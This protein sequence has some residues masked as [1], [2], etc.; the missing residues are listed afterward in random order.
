V[1][2][3][4]APVTFPL[5]RL[6]LVTTPDATGPLPMAKTTGMVAVA[7]FAAS[8]DGVPLIRATLRRIR[9]AANAAAVAHSGIQP[10][11]IRSRR[12]ALR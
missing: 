9:S 3:K 10:S 8:T 4:L 6:R 11:D 1:A 2:K 5:G 12:F 7:A